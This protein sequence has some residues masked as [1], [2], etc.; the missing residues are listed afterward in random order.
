MNEKRYNTLNDF[1]RK[2]FGT[3]VFKVSLDAGFSCP[4]KK[5]GGCTFCTR[6]PYIGDVNKDLNT[7]F[8]EVKEM[9]HKKWKEAKYIVYLEAGSNTYG[10]LDYL[11]S[12]YEP[13]I[14][15][16]NVVGLN[17]G[18]RCDCLNSEILDY[19]EDLSKRTYL[20]IELGL[21]SSHNTTLKRINRGHTKEDFLIKVKELKKRNINVVVHIINGLPN[22]TKEMMIETVKFLNNLNIDGIKIHMLYLENDSKLYKEYL[23]K[24][25]HILSKDEYI[26]ITCTQL[27]YLNK[28]I[29][30]HR[31]TGDPDKNKLVKPSYLVKK[32]VMLN[33]I[34]K[35]MKLNNIYQGDLTT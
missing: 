35:Y 24:P 31:I 26:D 33:D 14:K 8:I 4:N 17:I 18:T 25:F 28:D 9:L 29:V 15:L 10:K 2:K 1:Y 6:T 11:K 20:T 13:L 27:R 7:Q 12:I 16:D 21:Q 22:E 32:F 34:D 19:L 23:E 5:D 3:K 30:I